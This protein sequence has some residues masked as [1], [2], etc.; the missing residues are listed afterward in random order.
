TIDLRVGFKAENWNVSLFCKN[1]TNEIRPIS[2]G[3]DGGDANPVGT[4]APVLTLNQRFSFESVRTVGVRAGI[5][6]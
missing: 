3:S 4:A 6:F 5:N 1:C 2:I